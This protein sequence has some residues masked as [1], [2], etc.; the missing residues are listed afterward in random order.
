MTNRCLPWLLAATA[1]AAACATTEHG[2]R[3]ETRE[4]SPTTV[5]AARRPSLSVHHRIDALG[6]AMTDGVP[7]SGDF[8]AG[9]P[10][11]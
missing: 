8:A 10:F 7:G 9:A 5:P 4:A 11:R 2:D 1:L 6:A 3:A